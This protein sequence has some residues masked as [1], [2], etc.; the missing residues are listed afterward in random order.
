[1]TDE[2]LLLVERHLYIVHWVIIDSIY[3]NES[4]YGLGYDDLFQEGSIWLC[5]AAVSYNNGLSMFSTYA[6]V[7]VRN[8]LISYCRLMYRKQEHFERL[9]IGEHG[10]LTTKGDILE[11]ADYDKTHISML[12]TLALLESVKKEYQGVTRLGI[13]ALELKIQGHR[14]T[15]IAA[16]YQVPSTHVGAWISRAVKKLRK[17]EEFLAS[18]R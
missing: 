16:A 17:N 14:I 8:G 3:V 5:R 2:Q 15:D 13:E 7:V 10:E 12:E 1:M 9:E 6:K 18:I 4:I 11:S